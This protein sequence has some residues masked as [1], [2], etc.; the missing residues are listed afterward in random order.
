MQALLVDSHCH[1]DRLDL[2]SCGGSVA[3]ALALARGAGVGR[4][5]CIALDPDNIPAVLKLARDFPEVA[6]TVGVHPLHVHQHRCSA[7]E[8]R[9]WAQDQQVVAI[10]ETG[11]D[12]FYSPDT[13]EVQRDSFTIHLQVAG[14]IGLPV[15]V[16]TRDAAEDTLS[17]IKKHGSL[18][19][20]GVLHCFTESWDMARQ[21]MDLNFSISISGI[22]TFGN[23][24]ELREVVRRLPLDKM[25]VETDSPYLA[26]VPHRGK[27][28]Q[29][30]YVSHVAQ[31][32]ADIKGLPLQR[33]VEATTNNYD[34][35]FFGA[36]GTC[37]S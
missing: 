23:A 37:R 1:L 5:L 34:R 20:G 33:I 28:N 6:A 15:V 19:H 16:H 31:A 7:T 2:A 29:P 24:Q 32:V 22:V 35:L 13:G 10:G 8:L 4:V 12:Y 21:A 36:A 9:G 3:A 30:A 17:L 18:D 27:P 14:D 11:L 26:P 25:L